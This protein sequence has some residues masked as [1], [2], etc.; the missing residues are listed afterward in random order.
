M[1]VEQKKQKG[2]SSDSEDSSS[3]SEDQEQG[4]GLKVGIKRGR[5]GKYHIMC[6]H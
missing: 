1:A 6:S 2:E 3:E 4:V 5:P